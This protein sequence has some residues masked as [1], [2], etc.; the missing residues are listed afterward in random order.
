[1]LCCSMLTFWT[2]SCF[3]YPLVLAI[4]LF[5]LSS[6]I[7]Y[8]LV[9]AILLFWLSS[10]FG[11]RR[12]KSFNSVVPALNTYL[13]VW[14]V[15]VCRSFCMF[16]P[17]LPSPS[18]FEELL[19]STLWTREGSINP[20]PRRMRMISC[21]FNVYCGCTVYTHHPPSLRYVTISDFWNFVQINPSL[22]TRGAQYIY[23]IQK[24]VF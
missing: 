5:W 3:G 2:S 12:H 9:L 10:C 13:N 11:S 18:S 23:S 4:L 14:S 17:P 19:V 16:L 20:S 6:C 1:M 7:G 8:P 22:P 24:T 15:Y 21:C